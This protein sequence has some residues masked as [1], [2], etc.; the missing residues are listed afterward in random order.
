MVYESH[1]LSLSP[2]QLSINRQVFSTV[3]FHNSWVLFY[4]EFTQNI[5]ICN[6][7]GTF[8]THVNNVKTAFVKELKKEVLFE[9]MRV[10]LSLKSVCK[11][12]FC[13]HFFYNYNSTLVSQMYL[14]NL[15]IPISIS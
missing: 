2:Y 3:Y 5:N 7:F 13:I 4:K 10:Y 9:G 14:N 1:A 11:F 15:Y 8:I 12:K 6:Y